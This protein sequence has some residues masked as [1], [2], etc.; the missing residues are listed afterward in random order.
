MCQKLAICILC[1]YIMSINIA[2]NRFCFFLA[3][4]R[5]STLIFLF[6]YFKNVRS[7]NVLHFIPKTESSPHTLCTDDGG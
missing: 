3:C 1:M 2:Q 5:F 7:E 6:P 4:L